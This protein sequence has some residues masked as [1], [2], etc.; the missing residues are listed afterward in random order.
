MEDWLIE[1]K[2]LPQLISK[3]G[4]KNIQTPLIP[5]TVIKTFPD[6]T[7]GDAEKIAE[8][9]NAML[10][11]INKGMDSKECTDYLGRLVTKIVDHN[12]E[13]AEKN[14]WD[15]DEAGRITKESTRLIVSTVRESFPE[16]TL[17]KAILLTNA[18]NEMLDK[19]P[20]VEEAVTEFAK[21]G[22]TS[23]EVEFA[24]QKVEEPEQD[25]DQE[26]GL[27]IE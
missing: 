22:I 12:K 13:R 18:Y 9:F 8:A 20:E 1:S 16:L 21:E 15:V 3:F 27:G 4:G 2:Y 7:G 17:C 5:E 24:R 10:P 6:I 26:L 25:Q 23:G 11:E 19:M 14:G